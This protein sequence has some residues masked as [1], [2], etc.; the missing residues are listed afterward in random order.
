MGLNPQLLIG[1]N[2]VISA[3]NICK[4]FGQNVDPDLDLNFLILW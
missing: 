4:Q 3:G 2:L 1:V